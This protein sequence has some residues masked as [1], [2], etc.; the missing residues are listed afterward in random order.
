MDQKWCHMSHTD[1]SVTLN[2]KAPLCGAT[3]HVLVLNSVQV[4][5]E[6]TKD[7]CQRG[8]GPSTENTY[9]R[10]KACRPKYAEVRDAKNP[11]PQLGQPGP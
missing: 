8:R 4:L 2:Q 5:Q 6:S 7:C 9:F 3:E 10:K 1:T 11:K